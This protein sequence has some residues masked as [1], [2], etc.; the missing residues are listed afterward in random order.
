LKIIGGSLI[1]LGEPDVLYLN[2]GKG[3][4]TPVSWTDGTFLN[5]HGQP[6]QAEPAD[7]GLSVMFRDIN[8]D[9]APDLYVC[10]DFQTPDRIWIND[11]KGHFRA[12]PDRAV[13]NLS[14]L[15]GRGFR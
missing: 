9:G 8:G 10:N 7:M 6:L 5:E 14:F 1:E 15:D 3:I 11:G 2:D 12:M 13:R 4:F